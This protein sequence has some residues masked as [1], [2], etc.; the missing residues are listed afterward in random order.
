MVKPTDVIFQ[1]DRNNDGRVD[2]QDI[3]DNQHVDPTS[4]AADTIEH[5]DDG[6]PFDDVNTTRVPY[7]APVID[8]RDKIRKLKRMKAEDILEERARRREEAENQ[9]II[10]EE[11]QFQRIEKRSPIRKAVTAAV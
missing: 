8:E 1:P 2:F 6:T 11:A 10:D 4:N 3:P 7:D 5:A 9:K